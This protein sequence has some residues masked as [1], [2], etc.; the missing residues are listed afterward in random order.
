MDICC[1]DEGSCLQQRRALWDAF[2]LQL[3]PAKS[4]LLLCDVLINSCSLGSDCCYVSALCMGRVDW[5]FSSACVI[6]YSILMLPSLF[7]ISGNCFWS[8]SVS[9]GVGNGLA[10]LGS[11]LGS[12]AT[13][14]LESQFALKL[15][16]PQ[17]QKLWNT[18]TCI[19]GSPTARGYGAAVRTD[20]DSL[21]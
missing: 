16:S 12:S 20:P 13:G 3:L 17:W 14:S 8:C 2:G 7:S 5:V 11:R 9:D 6:W 18:S 4:A 21:T 15:N 10:G 19:Q 1:G